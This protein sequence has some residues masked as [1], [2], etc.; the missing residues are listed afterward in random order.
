MSKSALSTKL[1]HAIDRIEL[2]TDADNSVL[3]LTSIHEELGSLEGQ[4][5]T[6]KNLIT[7]YEDHILKLTNKAEI[8]AGEIESLK[9]ELKQKDEILSELK[10][11]LPIEKA[12]TDGTVYN[13][14]DGER[15][16][17]VWFQFDGWT[18]G[19][20]REIAVSAFFTK[21]QLNMFRPKIVHP[22]PSTETEGE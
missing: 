21:N 7:E 1:L 5:R 16:R 22:L 17:Y 2:K 6:A 14:H 9:A 20:S 15:W 19:T 11:G 18:D 10:E 3:L 12:K 13:W 8:M 4:H